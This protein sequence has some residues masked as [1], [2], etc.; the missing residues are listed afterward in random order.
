MLID[1]DRT[2]YQGRVTF[3]NFYMTYSGETR[4]VRRLWLT[5][6]MAGRT[7]VEEVARISISGKHFQQDGRPEAEMTDCCK[8]SELPGQWEEKCDP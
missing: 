2:K 3:D 1:P 7:K 6:R 4:R 8:A 5:R